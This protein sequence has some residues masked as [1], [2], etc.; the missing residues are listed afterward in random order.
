MTLGDDHICRR[1]DAPPPRRGESLAT[2][3]T[4]QAPGWVAPPAAEEGAFAAAAVG[5]V[6]ARDLFVAVLGDGASGG[7]NPARLPIWRR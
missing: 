7:Q 6:T 1:F 5:R 4:R 2:S 3:E